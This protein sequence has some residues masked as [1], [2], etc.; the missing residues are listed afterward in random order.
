MPT[1]FFLK[2]NILVGIWAYDTKNWIMYPD[3][4]Y[5]D[6]TAMENYEL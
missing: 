1:F 3:T 4:N 5:N 6:E 2:E